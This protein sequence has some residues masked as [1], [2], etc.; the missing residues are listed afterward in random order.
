MKLGWIVVS[1]VLIAV[2]GG[3]CA[4]ALGSR[5]A[6]SYRTVVAKVGSVSE[7]LD[8]TGT[9]HPVDSAQLAFQVAG[10]VASVSASVGQQVTQGEVLATLSTG[11]LVAA[12]DAAQAAVVS[13]QTKLAADEASEASL[14]SSA[15]AASA[16]VAQAPSSATSSATAGISALLARITSE[17]RQEALDAAKE[18]EA[19][20]LASSACASRSGSSPGAPASSGVGVASPGA[21]PALGTTTAGPAACLA[22]LQ[23]ALAAE[24]LVSVDQ[25]QINA[26]ESS[27]ERML[28]A[29]R[30]AASQKSAAPSGASNAG[31]GPPTTT[32]FSAVSAPYQIAADQAALDADEQ[33]LST[34]QAELSSAEIVSPMAGVV[35]AVAITPGATVPAASSSDVIVV[36]GPQSFEVSASVGVTDISQV[37]VGQSALVTPDGQVSEIAGTVTQVG[38]PPVATSASTAA[39]DYPVVVS[40]PAG[41]PGLFDGASASVAIVVQRSSGV[42]TVPTSAVHQIGQ[43]TFVSELA[44]GKMRDVRVVLGAMGDT[45]TAVTSGIKSGTPVVLANLDQPLP[46]I[47]ATSGRAAFAGIGALTGGGG[48]R[49]GGLRGAGGARAGGG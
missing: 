49:P 18:K 46:S 25:A 11:S 28:A 19:L 10:Q 12:E 41:T 26:G 8:T 1:V 43:F 27:M 3:T 48:F 29:A 33:S 44:G 20:G 24:H 45:L 15:S 7:T 32:S 37:K 35:A 42:V 23:K 30:G 38:P 22:A 9:L 16:Q 2:V 21:A 14:I 6:G 31:S 39:V 4:W 13:A 34:A 5:T 36:I 17:Q 47:N 40:L